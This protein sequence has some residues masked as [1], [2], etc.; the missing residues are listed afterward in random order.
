[1]RV[2]AAGQYIELLEKPKLP[3][4]IIEIACWVV[5]EYGYLAT[6]YDL[7]VAQARIAELLERQCVWKGLLFL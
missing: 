1:M 3:D 6:D 4:I 5:G 2:F 7:G